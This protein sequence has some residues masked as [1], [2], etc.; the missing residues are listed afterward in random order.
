MLKKVFYILCFCFIHFSPVIADTKS[1]P[2][3]EIVH[4]Y[5]LHEIQPTLFMYADILSRPKDELK[6]VF[7]GNIP[8]N[9][10]DNAKTVLNIKCTVLRLVCACSATYC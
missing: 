7:N 9:K 1:L 3:K 2:K 4:I 5:Y 6:I 8:E 10:V